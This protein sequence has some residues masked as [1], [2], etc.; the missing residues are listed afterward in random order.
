MLQ[1][2]TCVNSDTAQSL[3]H[4]RNLQHAIN[5]ELL[6][7]FCAMTDVVAIDGIGVEFLLLLLVCPRQLCQRHNVLPKRLVEK[8]FSC[9]PDE[10]KDIVFSATGVQREFMLHLSRFVQAVSSTKHF[11]HRL[12]LPEPGLECR[13]GIMKLRVVMS[14]E[15]E[16]EAF[17]AYLGRQ[18]HKLQIIP[19]NSRGQISLCASFSEKVVDTMQPQ[20]PFTAKTFNVSLHIMSTTEAHYIV[21]CALR[22]LA[23]S[24]LMNC[25]GEDVDGQAMLHSAMI[26]TES[27]WEDM[28]EPS[29]KPAMGG[30][31]NTLEGVQL[32]SYGAVQLM[33]V[34]IQTG[35]G[36]YRPDAICYI[37]DDDFEET[38]QCRRLSPIISYEAK[39]EQIINEHYKSAVC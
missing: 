8:L 37:P 7:L 14:V 30:L 2:G 31:H 17:V 3:I 9:I 22:K 15:I 23:Y 34:K 6:P 19:L 27:A 11:L 35:E 13:V 4:T 10:Q 21:V 26:N 1:S 36:I 25:R 38:S 20:A 16:I 29:R 33:H 5:E 28:F 39:V 12:Q 32:G 24:W 18:L